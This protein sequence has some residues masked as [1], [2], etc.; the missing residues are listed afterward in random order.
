MIRRKFKNKNVLYVNRDCPSSKKK[1]WTDAE[2][3][4]HLSLLKRYVKKARKRGKT[5]IVFYS[6]KS[7]LRTVIKLKDLPLRRTK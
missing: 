6:F 7:D 5:M 4:I 2:G 3:K 1:S